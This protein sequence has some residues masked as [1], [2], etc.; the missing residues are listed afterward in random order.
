[1]FDKLMVQE[2]YLSFLI[3]NHDS[4]SIPLPCVHSAI[5]PPLVLIF[6][7]AFNLH[8]DWLAHVHVT[9]ISSLIG[10]FQVTRWESVD[11]SGC[12]VSRGGPSNN[13]LHIEV[14]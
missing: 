9:P 4:L 2:L 7:R 6:A 14:E 3:S 1:M 8:S 12:L 10:C 5:F 13:L 11:D